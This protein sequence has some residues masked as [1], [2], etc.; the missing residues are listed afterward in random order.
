VFF[1]QVDRLCKKEDSRLLCE[2]EMVNL[3]KEV[4]LLGELL[5]KYREKEAAA[6]EATCELDLIYIS[7]ARQE[8]SG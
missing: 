8:L 2:Q 7:S 5:R 4:I 1:S 3:R 6:S